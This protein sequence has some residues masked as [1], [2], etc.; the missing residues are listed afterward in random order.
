[1]KRLVLLLFAV[2][3]THP[4]AAPAQ[5]PD[6]QRWSSRPRNVMIVRDDWASHTSSADRC[7]RSVWAIY[8]Q[9]GTT[10]S[11]EHTTSTRW[12]VWRRRRRDLPSGA[13]CA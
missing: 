7:R 13:I 5:G 8:A 11:V 4:I 2:G 3:R 6:L 1:M 10:Q 12:G 9:A